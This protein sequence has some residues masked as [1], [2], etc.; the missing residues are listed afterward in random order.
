[1]SDNRPE[2]A[3]IEWIRSQSSTSPEV[4]LGIGDDAAILAASSFESV[5]T[6][7]VIMSGVHFTPDMPLHLVGRKALAVNIS[8]IAAMG[9]RPIAAFIGIVLP[10]TFTR[11]DA[12]ALYAGLQ[13]LAAEWNIAIAGGDTNSWDGPLV[14]SVTL[15]GHVEAGTA[16]RRDGA[17]P[18]DWIFVTGPLGGSLPSGRHLN[19]TPRVKEAR[20]L[21]SAVSLHAMLDLSDGLGSDLFHILDRS[22]VGAKIFGDSIPIH[23]EV[24][25]TLPFA[26]RLNHAIS[27]GED[28]ELLFTLSADEGKQLLQSPPEGVSVFHIGEITAQPDAVL[29]VNEKE[30]FLTRT[31]WAHQFGSVP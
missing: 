5:V 19:F 30:H 12:E 13:S 24:D 23:S 18:G 1:M 8:D 22:N 20:S 9:A 27:D 28:F 10:K 2:F 3:L 4:L 17:K 6:K 26:D 16:I 25:Q 7:D 29:I 21:K 11:A 15:I 14:I 31:G